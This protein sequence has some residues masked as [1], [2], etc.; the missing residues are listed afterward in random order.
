MIMSLKERNLDRAKCTVLVIQLFLQNCAQPHE[1]R[2]YV[3]P[4]II[5]ET[6]KVLSLL[7]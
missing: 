1:D 6:C 5:D 7:T 4:H 2:A 3:L